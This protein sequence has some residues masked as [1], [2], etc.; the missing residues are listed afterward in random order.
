MFR[1]PEE[2]AALALLHRACGPESDIGRAYTIESQAAAVV[3]AVK[4][5]HGDDS[6][7]HEDPAYLEAVAANKRA[8]LALIKTPA[9]S[10]PELAFKLAIIVLDHRPGDPVYMHE[11]HQD[12]GFLRIIAEIRS[13]ASAAPPGRKA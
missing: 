13:V 2:Q 8:T 9:R 4:A 12:A 5:K 11:P 7:Y 6:P 1:D 10:I 3:E